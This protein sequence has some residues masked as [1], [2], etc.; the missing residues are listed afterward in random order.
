MPLPADRPTPSESGRPC[1]STPEGYLQE[2][3][4][5]SSH[6]Q[7]VVPSPLD[8]EEAAREAIRGE[9]DQGGGPLRGPWACFRPRK[10]TPEGRLGVVETMD[11][12]LREAPRRDSTLSK[13][14]L[15]VARERVGGLRG[16]CEGCSRTREHSRTHPREAIA[17]VL[18]SR[19]GGLWVLG[20][21]RDAGRGTG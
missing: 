7:E 11:E 1:R 21:P 2:R 14:T 20:G 16:A 3:K 6:L 8:H 15:G 19:S 4:L 9:S 10:T 12:G 13:G 5:P 17:E 18:V